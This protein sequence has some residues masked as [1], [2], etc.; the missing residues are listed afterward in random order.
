MKKPQNVIIVGQRTYYAARLL[1]HRF[2]ARE[3]SG[4]WITAEMVT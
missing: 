1:L 3:I 4:G 2:D